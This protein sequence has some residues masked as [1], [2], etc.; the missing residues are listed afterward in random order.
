M[1]TCGSKN[2]KKTV[3]TPKRLN[4][5]RKDDDEM[6]QVDLERL[7]AEK[8]Q[9]EKQEDELT[10]LIYAEKAALREI[11]SRLIVKRA[12]CESLMDL[13]EPTELLDI[14]LDDASFRAQKRYRRKALKRSYC[15]RK[16]EWIVSSF[17]TYSC[18]C[19]YVVLL[20]AVAV[21]ILF[22]CTITSTGS[23]SRTWFIWR[24]SCRK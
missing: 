6:T 11:T 10:R 17:I 15:A 22:S 8:L 18:H 24:S 14:S 1:G 20:R 16:N 9:R 12:S 23:A 5:N 2:V 3:A 19:F 4:K 7:L 21:C 13:L